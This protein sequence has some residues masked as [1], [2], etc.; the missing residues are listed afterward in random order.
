LH[1]LVSTLKND[2]S[3]DVAEATDQADFELL[4]SRKKVVIH[5]QDQ[6]KENLHRQKLLDKREAKENEQKKRRLEEDD[7][8]KFYE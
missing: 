8:Y 5:L 6:E 2:V 4:K 3:A 7:E 1:E